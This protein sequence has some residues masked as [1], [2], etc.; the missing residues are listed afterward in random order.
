MVSTYNVVSVL[1]NGS[2]WGPMRMSLPVIHRVHRNETNEDVAFTMARSCSI[3]YS[4]Y[5]KMFCYP[6]QLPKNICKGICGSFVLQAQLLIE[7]R[8]I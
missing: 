1:L 4:T 7:F 8:Q 5:S 6:D 3:H 2:A